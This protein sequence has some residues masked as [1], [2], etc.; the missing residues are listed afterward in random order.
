MTAMPDEPQPPPEV[1]DGTYLAADT[2]PKPE[3]QQQPQT[4][5]AYPGSP[6]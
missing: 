4:S 5:D 2:P 1:T 3:P 6:T